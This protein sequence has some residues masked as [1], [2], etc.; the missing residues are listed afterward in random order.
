MPEFVTVASVNDIPEGEMLIV[1]VD[2]DDIVIANLGGGEFVAFDNVCTHKGGPMGEGMMLPGAVIEC[3]F[4]GGQFNA[5]T[6]EVVG[7][8]PTEPLPVYQVQV[9][10][11]FIKVAKP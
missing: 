3:P 8:P 7:P 10:G 11:E 4:H 2:G 5:R 6:G 1:T 9:E